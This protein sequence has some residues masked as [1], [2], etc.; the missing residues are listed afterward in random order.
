MRFP[1]EPLDDYFS[2]RPQLTDAERYTLV[3][4][5]LDSWDAGPDRSIL[6]CHPCRDR[7]PDAARLDLPPAVDRVTTMVPAQ[8][9]PKAAFE[10]SSQP[11]SSRCCEDHLYPSQIWRVV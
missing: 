2:N 8:I 1:R 6:T 5:N 3:K 11:P 10:C 4:S 9:D 7:C